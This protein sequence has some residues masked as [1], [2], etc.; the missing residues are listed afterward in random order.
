MGESSARGS[1]GTLEHTWTAEEPAFGLKL[2]PRKGDRDDPFGVVVSEVTNPNLPPALKGTFIAH[3]NGT[4][5]SAL[6]Y[7]EVLA[8]A[9][10]AER[11]VTIQFQ[12]PESLTGPIGNH[13]EPNSFGTTSDSGLFGSD[14]TGVVGKAHDAAPTGGGLFGSA[15]PQPG[16]GQGGG[17]F[18]SASPQPGGGLF[19]ATKTDS[20]G[21]GG[22]VLGAS[23]EPAD[24]DKPARKK[25]PEPPLPGAAGDILRRVSHTWENPGTKLFPLIHTLNLSPI[26]G[27]QVH[28]V[29]SPR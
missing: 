6:C 26:Q 10:D 29:A 24:T 1:M 18:G 3:I 14:P 12:P 5:C 9:N 7:R 17:L 8:L 19:G 25:V 22:S 4:D 15:S 21:G 28:H 2:K 27:E 13:D 23:T 20:G 16:G 11:P